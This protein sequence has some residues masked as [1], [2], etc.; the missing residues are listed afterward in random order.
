MVLGGL[1]EGVEGAV[2]ELKPRKQG[3]GR[4][5]RESVDVGGTEEG[6]QG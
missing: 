3:L 5:D 6:R 4:E 2:E 1:F